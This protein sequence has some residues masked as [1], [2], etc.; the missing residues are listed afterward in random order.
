MDQSIRVRRY[1]VFLRY[2]CKATGLQLKTLV[3]HSSDQ[4]LLAICEVLLNVLHGNIYTKFD[5]QK[6]IDLLKTLSSKTVPVDQKR[7][8]LVNSVI[9]R[10]YIKRLLC[11]LQI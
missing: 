5:I 2:F 1:K 10:L 7:H 4:E 9:Y 3:E 8:I 6:R 11:S